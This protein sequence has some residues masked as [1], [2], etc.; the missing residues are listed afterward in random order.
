[1][2]GC[3]SQ[4]D[5]PKGHCGVDTA[6]CAFGR[7]GILIAAPEAAA[8]CM[9]NDGGRAAADERINDEVA[10]EGQQLDEPARQ[11]LGKRGRIV[12]ALGMLAAAPRPIASVRRPPH[13]RR[14]S[15]KITVTRNRDRRV[16]PYPDRTRSSHVPSAKLR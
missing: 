15:P 1:V 7:G 10:G 6:T 13:S 12:N 11:L 4:G 8:K 5:P 2:R 14:V 16:S 3:Q 9:C